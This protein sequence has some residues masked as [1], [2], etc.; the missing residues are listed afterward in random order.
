MAEKVV[1]IEQLDENFKGLVRIANKEYH[2][3][4]V[5]KDEEV[6]LEVSKDQS[7]CV[8]KKVLKPSTYRVNQLCPIFEKCGGCNLQHIDYEYQLKMKT[9]FV[10]ELF[11]NTLNHYYEVNDTL[12]MK[13]PTHYR[14]K[15]QVVFRNMPNVKNR[16]ISGFYEEGSHKVVDFD[17][18]LIQDEVSDSIVKTIKELMLKMHYQAYDDTRRT[19][20]IR[21]VLIKRSKSTKE[22][23]VV[24]VTGQEVFPGSSNFVKAL[25]ARY[26]DIKT[27]IQNVNNKFT[28]SVLGDKEKV[29]YGKGYITDV[30]LGKKFNISS[31]SFYQINSSQCEVLY[32]EALK[33]AMVTKKDVLL[34]AYSGVGTIGIIASD[35]VNK[36]ISVELVK[37]AVK[38]AINNAKMNNIK[39][40]H[41][42][43]ADASEFMKNLASKKE[44]VDVVIMDPP[45]KGSDVKFMNSVIKLSPRVVIYISCDPRTQVNDCSYFINNGYNI[46]S[47]QPVDMFP[48]TMHI[49][50]IVCLQ[51]KVSK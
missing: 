23:M 16:L 31:K 9:S 33:H 8:L 30:F 19:G 10:E 38:D 18:C 32:K 14:N 41:F 17:T 29:L 4:Y 36:V 48:Y 39:N 6:L 37:D 21:H 49:E 20:L 3:P 42:F 1:K 15:N 34:D 40:I 2:I 50:N 5:I 12:G 35:Y 27:I 13:D 22:I 44:R 51:K 7:N 47:I 43:Q 28:S 24:I 45:R 46:T 26:K 11:F 25:V